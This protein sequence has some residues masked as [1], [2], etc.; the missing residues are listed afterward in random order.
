MIAFLVLIGSVAVYGKHGHN[1]SCI[2]TNHDHLLSS[3]VVS[4]VIADIDKDGDGIVEPTEVQ[5]FVAG[6]DLDKNGNI[7]ESEFTLQWHRHYLDV[8][9]FVGYLFQ[10]F[11]MNNDMRLTDSDLVAWSK[12]LDTDGNGEISIAEFRTYMMNLYTN[13]VTAHAN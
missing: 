7:T 3:Q 1:H 11:D 13:C 2:H 4:N 12:N 9:D 6:Y 5:H 8:R 10:N